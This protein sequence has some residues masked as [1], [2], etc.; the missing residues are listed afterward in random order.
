MER[1]GRVPEL[2]AVFWHQLGADLLYLAQDVA[3]ALGE[4]PPTLEDV[5]GE[6]VGVVVEAHA[7]RDQACES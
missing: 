3:V 1:R 6:L 2:L 5:E 4:S 7:T